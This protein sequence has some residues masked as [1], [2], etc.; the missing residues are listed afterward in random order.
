MDKQKI[1][2]YPCLIKKQM[3]NGGIEHII[4][5]SLGLM[6]K[7]ESLLPKKIGLDEKIDLFTYFTILSYTLNKYERETHTAKTAH[8][9]AMACYHQGY[10]GIKHLCELKKTFLNKKLIKLSEKLKLKY[11]KRIVEEFEERFRNLNSKKEKKL[12]FKEIDRLCVKEVLESEEFEQ[13]AINE[14]VK[15]YEEISD[16]KIFCGMGRGAFD[17]TW[18]LENAA[19]GHLGI[20]SIQDSIKSCLDANKIIPNSI[21]V[22]SVIVDLL[23]EFFNKSFRNNIHSHSLSTREYVLQRLSREFSFLSE[24]LPVEDKGLLIEDPKNLSKLELKQRLNLIDKLKKESWIICESFYKEVTKEIS[25][26]DIFK[27]KQLGISK[28]EVCELD[29]PFLNKLLV[30]KKSKKDDSNLE[31]EKEIIE[32]Y[33]VKCDLDFNIINFETQEDGKYLFLKRKKGLNFLK[34]LEIV[35]E[36]GKIMEDAQDYQKILDRSSNFLSHYPNNFEYLKFL[37]ENPDNVN[38]N[39]KGGGTERAL[40][41]FR[42]FYSKELG[43][44]VFLSTLIN[45]NFIHHFEHCLEELAKLNANIPK[46]LIKKEFMKRD[47]NKGIPSVLSSFEKDLNKKF[48]KRFRNKFLKNYDTIDSIL[49]SAPKYLYKDSYL[50]NWIIID[51]DMQFKK[52]IP[53]DFERCAIAPVQLDLAFLLDFGNFL[54]SFAYSDYTKGE[55][56]K[57]QLID[58]YIDKFNETSS[59][60]DTSNMISDRKEF[61]RIFDYAR[62][63]RNLLTFNSYSK[64]IEKGDTSKEAMDYKRISLENSIRVLQKLIGYEKDNLYALKSLH[65]NLKKVYYKIYK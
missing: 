9:I 48:S 3:Q 11:R 40:S 65:K 18:F 37:F 17:P 6:K 61:K 62:V 30:I 21:Y 58:Y 7:E 42:K 25:V 50:K 28:N 14:A 41:S 44:K 2:S 56:L 13:F 27:K 53:I 60:K 23:E 29:N 31:S 22:Y 49:S 12:A 34:Y 1:K 5:N 52:V 4:L 47:Y 26:W 54:D 20:G 43:S 36:I 15:I 10:Q 38:E 8:Y 39:V 63:H 16:N 35:K 57:E 64:F 24:P 45:L 59:I 19:I 51:S 33:K 32:Y 46:H 55:D